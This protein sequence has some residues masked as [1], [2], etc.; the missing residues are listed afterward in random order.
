MYLDPRVNAGGLGVQ[1]KLKDIRFCAASRRHL[2]SVDLG[3]AWVRVW[4]ISQIVT[5]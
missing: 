1:E 3:A 5:T 2:V 4:Q